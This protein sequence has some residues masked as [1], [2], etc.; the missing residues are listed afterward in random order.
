LNVIET[1]LP[2]VLILEPQVFG[3]ERGWFME[4][5]NSE[6]FRAAGI[7]QEFVQDNHSRSS[8]G[9]LRGLHYQEPNPQ[10]KLVRCPRGSL[11]DVAVDI[12]KGS[13]TFGRW[14]GVEL[15]DENKR[16][17]WVPPGFAH[18]FCVISEMAELVYK[19]TSLYE[20]ANDRAIRWND[21]D[22]GIAW[23]IDTT[24]PQLST[25]DAAAPLLAN[26]R[27]LPKYEPSAE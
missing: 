16:M 8:R 17:L 20:P 7:P 6:R 21:P 19:V 15:N 27:V 24:A 23:P 13:P 4:T 11:F 26:A 12:R 2:G 5:Y 25:K 3:D 10:G 18:G 9:V 1:I 14:F 22:I